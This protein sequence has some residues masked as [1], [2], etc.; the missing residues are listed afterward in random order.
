M[1]VLDTSREIGKETRRASNITYAANGTGERLLGR[2]RNANRAYNGRKGL[3]RLGGE[4]ALNG[5]GNSP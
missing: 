5:N 1:L 3:V 2:D 4:V